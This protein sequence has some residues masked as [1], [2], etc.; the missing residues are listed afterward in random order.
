MKLRQEQPHLSIKQLSETTLPKLTV[1]TGVN[2]SGKTHLLRAIENGCVVVDI[3]PTPNTDIRFFDWTNL[4]PNEAAETN[5]TTIYSEREQ[6]CQQIQTFKAQQNEIL[7]MTISRF[8]LMNLS[9]DEK[10]ALLDCDVASLTKDISTGGDANSLFKQLERVKQT[11]ETN[12]RNHFRKNRKF[13]NLIDQFISEKGHLASVKESDFYSRPFGWDQGDMFQ[14]SFATMFLTYFELKKTNMI[15]KAMVDEGEVPDVP[16]LSKDDFIAQHGEAPWDF[17]NETI[18]TAGL[19]FSIDHPKEL[20]SIKYRPT[21][22][23]NSSGAEVSFTA[24]SSGEKVLM[25]FAFCLYYSLDRRQTVQRPKLLLF[26]E[27]DAPLHPSMSKVLM[28]TINKMLVEKHGIHVIFVTHSPSTV[29]VAPE[30]AIHLI[31]PDT[32]QISKESKRRAIS[33][34]TAGIPILSIDFEGRRQVFVES[35]KDAVRY[36]KLYAR[37]EASLESD[38]SLS[39]IGVGGRNKDGNDVGSGSAQVK[40]LVKEFVDGGNISVFGI[41]DWDNGRNS[42]SDRIFALAEGHRYSIE[43][44]LLDPLLIA[45]L[46]YCEQRERASEFNWSVPYTDFS[47]QKPSE[48]ERIANDI[49]DRVL[50]TLNSSNQSTA[51]YAYSG[52]LTLELPK[53]YM[54]VNGHDLEAAIIETFPY[55]TPASKTPGLMLKVINHVLDDHPSFLPNE[56]LNT[57]RSI[58]S[59]ELQ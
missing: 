3:A 28:E 16:P 48:L 25:S 12:T 18:Q 21:L 33:T 2:G 51:E 32:N 41:V 37:Y 30:E 53:H 39:F 20:E 23:K 5:I 49:A 46:I 43:N 7:G 8:G 4:V 36:D 1:L 17:V 50:T 22:T 27:I 38:R 14:Q 35:Q 9:D 56:I 55:L 31:H 52:G 10:W 47:T 45:T 59:Y 19:D 26:D 15:R 40:R 13:Q 24:L 34:L 42:T 11:L 6:F 44:C 29:A 57:F 58:L 54:E